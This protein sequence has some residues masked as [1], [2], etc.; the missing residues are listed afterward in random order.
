M[1]TGALP[2]AHGIR[3]YE[4]PV[5]EFDTIFDSIIRAGKRAAIESVDDSSIAKIFLEQN[6]DYLIVRATRKSTPAPM[7]QSRG[8]PTTWSSST[9]KITTTLSME[10]RLGP[11]KPL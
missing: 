8:T 1:F 10:A 4:K 9:T 5:L 7:M 2:E 3:Q 11:G 6:I